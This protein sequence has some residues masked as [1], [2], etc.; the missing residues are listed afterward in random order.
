[1]SK[2]SNKKDLFEEAVEL[3]KK[4]DEDFEPRKV[5]ED[6]WMPAVD[7]MYGPAK[8]TLNYLGAFVIIIVIYIIYKI[9]KKK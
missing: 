3:L 2:K 8:S 5:E 1:M 7:P 4:Y 6:M 9:M